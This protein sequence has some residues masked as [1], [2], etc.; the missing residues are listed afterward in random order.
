MLSRINKV[1][2]QPKSLTSQKLFGH[3]NFMFSVISGLCMNLKL[4]PTISFEDRK[5]ERTVF[6]SHFVCI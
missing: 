1:I 6:F 2:Q 5:T 4:M 3:Y